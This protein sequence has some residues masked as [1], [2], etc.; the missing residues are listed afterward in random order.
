MY[1]ISQQ[2]DIEKNPGPSHNTSENSI[3]SDTSGSYDGLTILHLNTRS[4]RNK[5]T[6]ILDFADGINILCFTETHLSDEI[7]TSDLI[8]DNYEIPFRLDR[9][10]HGGGILAYV[11]K[12]ILAKRRTDLENSVDEII[13]FEIILKSVKYLICV[14]YRPPNTQQQFWSRFERS[15]SLALD[16]SNNLVVIGDLNIDFFQQLPPPFYDLITTKNLINVITEPTRICSTRKSLLDPILITDSIQLLEQG[17]LPVENTISD[18]EA[19]F[20]AFKIP[21]YINHA[22]TREI[23]LYSKA[24]VDAIKQD[25][26]N[27][28][29]ENLL[30]NISIDE[31]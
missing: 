14:V 9:S 3:L 26:M 2:S 29:W 31:A 17:T 13:W 30:N 16:E 23:W 28:D 25:I 8:I 11:M 27:T 22:Y 1:L 18:H 12:G 4:I 24:N 5:I 15:V 10:N 21:T 6:K 19:T 20:A 7:S